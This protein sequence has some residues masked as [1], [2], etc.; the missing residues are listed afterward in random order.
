MMFVTILKCAF[1]DIRR[2]SAIRK[3]YS[4]EYPI[5]LLKKLPS[6]RHELMLTKSRCNA[7]NNVFLSRSKINLLLLLV[8]RVK[9]RIVTD[10]LLNNHMK[11][12]RNVTPVHEYLIIP[13]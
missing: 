8:Q 10:Q 4:R 9:D 1:C 7:L 2:I 11:K 3:L 5:M 6:N 12:R 13:D